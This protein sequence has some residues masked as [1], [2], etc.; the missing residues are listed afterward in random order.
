MSKIK[1]LWADDEIELLKP[2]ILFLEQKG[3]TIIPVL[4]GDEALDT[5][6]Q[7]SGIHVVLLDEN[8]PG[9]SGLETLLRIKKIRDSIPVIMITKSE[10]EHLM[11]EAIG[12]KIADYLIKPVNPNQILLALKKVLDAVRLLDEKTQTDYRKT[13]SELGMQ[14]Q[15]ASTI[16]DWIKVYKDLVFWSL[17]LEQTSDK[18]M[19]DIWSMQLADANKAFCKYVEKQYSSWFTST[20]KAPLM[21]HTLLKSVL[22]PILDQEPPVF[23][24]VIDNL[25]LDQWHILQPILAEHF[26]PES[27]GV[28]TSILPT[29]TQ[30]AR[31]A[32]F[33][34][35]MPGEL[36]K[37][38]PHYWVHDHEE[39]GK[40]QHEEILLREQLNRYGKTHKFS[41]HKIT[42][43]Q[44]GKKLQDQL[45]N[46]YTNR[47]NVIVY[48]FVDMISHARTEMDVIRELAVDE[49]AYRSLTR[50][51]FM[52]SPLY[53]ILKTLA[54]KSIRIMIT[55][56]HGTIR[57]K[58]PVRVTADRQAS[59]NLRYKLGKTMEYSSKSVTECKNPSDW[60]LPQPFSGSRF[61]FACESDYLIYPNQ[62]NYYVQHFK[63]TFQHGGISLE[64]ML[65]PYAVFKSRV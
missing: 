10:E 47:L 45:H 35:L 39:A 63:D 58:N 22:V 31:N 6:V 62:Y 40:N 21:S 19:Q 18:S 46:L 55:T 29:A 42:N 23:L 64:E 28:Y 36:Q 57:V 2:H 65:I 32:L 44:G 53:D 60:Y 37:K 52:H 54:Q 51:W 14:I 24:I 43:L 11:E 17:Q 49:S 9:L 50:S 20:A 38:Y 7:D 27:E 26:M 1:V 48:N 8:M 3:Y 59:T 34:G 5:L 13:F 12:S 15:D 30:Y 41:Y 61:I 16:S 33:S 56:D 4:S 25:R